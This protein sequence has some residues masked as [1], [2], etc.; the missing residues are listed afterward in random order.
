MASAN[1]QAL[2][3]VTILSSSGTF[4]AKSVTSFPVLCCFL[5]F[6]LNLPILNKDC[7]LRHNK[8]F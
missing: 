3:V 1:G 4:Q 2:P 6:N 8:K 7:V 5:F